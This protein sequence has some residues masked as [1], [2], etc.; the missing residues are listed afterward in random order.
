LSVGSSELQI[1]PSQELGKAGMREGPPTVFAWRWYYHLVS[2]AFWALVVLPALL[3]KE[4]RRWQA[5]TILIPLGLI[6]VICQMLA[7]LG[8]QAAT[9]EGLQTF[10]VT[11]ATAWAAVWLLG[12]WFASRHGRLRLAAAVTVMLAVGLLSY[13][14]DSGVLK[15]ESL[16]PLSVPYVGFALAL[17]LPMSLSGWC[18]RRVYS[19]RRFMLWL[20]LWMPVLLAG[21]MLLFVGG[22]T[23]VMGVT[24]GPAGAFT[25]ILIMVPVMAL[26][27]GIYGVLLYLM[28]LP[29]MLLAFRNSFY[30]ERFC[31]VF[32]LQPAPDLAGAGAEIS[33]RPSAGGLD[34]QKTVGQAPRA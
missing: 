3:V 15:L 9:A 22:L 17:M 4:N 26:M 16:A 5:W 8:S 23:L 20:L 6:V 12:F 33:E 32:G 14:C 2:L 27:G 19:P 21:V 28:N 29:F 31:K 18:C 34:D 13:V 1:I 30:R 24:A 25:H 7:G 11:L 10:F